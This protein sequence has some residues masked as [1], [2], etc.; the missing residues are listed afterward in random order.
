MYLELKMQ[1]TRY[2]WCI[3]WCKCNKQDTVE[4]FKGYKA[5]SKV[6]LIYLG[7]KMQLVRIGSDLKVIKKQE[8]YG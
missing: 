7:V 6:R 3:Q 8:R 1:E 4:I 2:D 5:R